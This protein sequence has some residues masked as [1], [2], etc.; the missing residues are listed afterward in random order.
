MH[1]VVTRKIKEIKPGWTEKEQ[2]EAKEDTS[3]DSQKKNK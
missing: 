1:T 2:L 3:S